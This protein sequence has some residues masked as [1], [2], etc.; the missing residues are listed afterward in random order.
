MAQEQYARIGE[1]LSISEIQG[2]IVTLSDYSSFAIRF[3]DRW[4][5][6][7]WSPEHNVFVTANDDK[8]NAYRLTSINALFGKDAAA[9]II[10]YGIPAKHSE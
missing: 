5:L 9:K 6:W 8:K 4:K 2:N 10:T 3:L 7:F 1:P